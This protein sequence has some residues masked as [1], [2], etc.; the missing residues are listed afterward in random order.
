VKDALQ[1]GA[2]NAVKLT[3]RPDRYFEN[4]AIKILL[5]KNLRSLEK[6]DRSTRVRVLQPN[7]DLL[8]DPKS[9]EFYIY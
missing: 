4:E 7:P 2:G 9:R 3:G 6:N 1:I 8:Y 5:P